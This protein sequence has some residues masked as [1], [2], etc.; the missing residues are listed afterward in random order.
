MAVSV[1]DTFVVLTLCVHCEGMAI[2][3]A[4]FASFI[5][6]LGFFEVKADKQNLISRALSKSQI[7]CKELKDCPIV[8]PKN[9]LFQNS[10]QFLVSFEE[11]REESQQIRLQRGFGRVRRR[12]GSRAAL[13][14]QK[15]G[16]IGASFAHQSPQNARAFVS[17]FRADG[18]KCAVVLP[19]GERATRD[20][21]LRGERL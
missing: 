14:A 3:C 8:D 20:V 16:Q 7:A 6:F 15:V 11:K 13:F 17:A 12:A 21:D 1:G 19:S 4:L 10:L 9:S 18:R 2:V 5:L